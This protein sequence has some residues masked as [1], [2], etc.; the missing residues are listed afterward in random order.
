M[1]DIDQ[2]AYGRGSVQ[3][4]E[5]LFIEKFTDTRIAIWGKM[6]YD[7]TKYGNSWEDFHEYHLS[8]RKRL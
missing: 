7:L 3:R 1:R 5:P 4:A 6:L 2:K 8:H